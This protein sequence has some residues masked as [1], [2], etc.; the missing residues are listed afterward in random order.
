ML[1]TE[2]PLCVVMMILTTTTIWG[3]GCFRGDKFEAIL[4]SKCIDS[5]CLPPPPCASSLTGHSVQA[6][7]PLIAWQLW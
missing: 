6:T 3:K 7:R 1:N 2:G 4:Y 5:Q